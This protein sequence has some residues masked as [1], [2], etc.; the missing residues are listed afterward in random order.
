MSERS[1]SLAQKRSALR[2]HCAI[3]RAELARHAGQIE[4]CL[5][6]VDRGINMVK[7]YATQPLLVIGG[8]ALIATLGPRRLVRWMSRGAVF[9]TAGRRL[10][11]LLR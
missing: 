9:V 11:R 8:V 6:P 1:I 2:T 7:H 3:Q 10:M 5:G 4:A